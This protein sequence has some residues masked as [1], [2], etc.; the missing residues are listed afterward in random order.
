MSL[1]DNW[2]SITVRLSRKSYFPGATISAMV[3]IE[4]VKDS[5]E[6]EYISYITAQVIIDPNIL[7]LASWT[8]WCDSKSR[9]ASIRFKIRK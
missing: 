2:L 6:G 5:E 8:C 9:R 7:F 3:S 1:E 4:P